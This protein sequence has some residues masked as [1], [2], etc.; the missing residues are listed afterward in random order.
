M[1]RP[2]VVDQEI[3]ALLNEYHCRNVGGKDAKKGNYPGFSPCIHNT[4]FYLVEN[5]R[6]FSLLVFIAFARIA[7]TVGIG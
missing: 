5:F 6:D 3:L 7:S 4:L 2:K 1:I